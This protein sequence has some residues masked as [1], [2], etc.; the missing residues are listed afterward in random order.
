MSA[1]KHTPAPWRSERLGF[2]HWIVGAN[3]DQVAVSYGA[4]VNAAAAANLALISVAPDL[5]AALKQAV[6][7]VTYCR[8]AHKDF[9]SGDGIPVEA[10]W[11]ELIAKAEGR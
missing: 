4:T 2:G 10:F 9:Q 11:K 1:A 6:E 7:C 3:G 5:L 8:R